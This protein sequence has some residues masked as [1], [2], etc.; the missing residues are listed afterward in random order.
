MFRNNHFGC[1]KKLTPSPEES[2][3]MIPPKDKLE[4]LLKGKTGTK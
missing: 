2:K 4:L 1:G 3:Q